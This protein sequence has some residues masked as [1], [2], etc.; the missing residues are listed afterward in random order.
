LILRTLFSLTVLAAATATARA[1]AV[2]DLLPPWQEGTLDIH[3][4]STARGNSSLFVFPDG[5]TMLLDAGALSSVRKG[6]L[7]GRS[8]AT[9]TP[10][11]IVVRYVRHMLAHD[12]EPHLDYALLTHFH[13]DHMGQITGTEA[14]SRLGPYRLSGI[15]EVGDEIPIRTLLDR[16]WPDYAYQPEPLKGPLMANYRAFVEWHK[17]HRGLTAERFRPGRNDQIVLKRA[18]GKY[19]NFEVRNVAVNGDVWTGVASET[20]MQFPPLEQIPAED[21]P[22]ENM[23]SAVFRLSFGK[24]DYYSGGDIPGIVFDNAPLWHDIETPVAKALGP[25]EVAILDHHGYIDTQ[26]PFFVATL[27]PRIW[28]LSVWH[29]AHPTGE[30]YRRLQSQRLYP[31]P[32]DLFMT[33]MHEATAS[34]I[35]SFK[36]ASTH[37]HIVVRVSGDGSYRIF[38]LDDR[39]ES[40]RI[41]AI[42]GPYQSR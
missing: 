24:F 18:P 42:H 41:T 7:D 3:Q 13:D 6:F 28:L 22:T 5:T 39:T 25:V 32:R 38:I 30:V 36:P 29:V 16:G 20:R 10:G 37:G 19:P 26:N 31:G 15:T 11:S 33:S 4:I 8:D 34:A 2:G 35:N 21:R 27:R 17:A 9:R 14:A 40:Y 23:C 12:A 1:Q